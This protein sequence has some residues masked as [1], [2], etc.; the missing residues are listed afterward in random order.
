[1]GT[2]IPASPQ[3]SYDGINKTPTPTDKIPKTGRPGAAVFPYYFTTL[4]V[5]IRVNN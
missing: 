4:L 3:Q 5:N 1:M 2:R